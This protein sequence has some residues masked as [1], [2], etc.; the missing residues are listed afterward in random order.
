M[1]KKISLKNN[2]SLIKQ[3]ETLKKR[4]RHRLLGSIFILI[5]ALILLLN[6]TSRE[7]NIII[8]P[9][10]I[11]VNG[12]NINSEYK[13]NNSK[14]VDTKGDNIIKNINNHESSSLAVMTPDE[15]I[16][17][18]AEHFKAMVIATDNG[19][20]TATKVS[21]ADSQVKPDNH[22]HLDNYN[23]LND[24][25]P[26]FKAQ[27][28]VEKVQADISPEDI[29]N[30]N[31]SNSAISSNQYYVQLLASSNKSRLEKLQQQL[32]DKR[33]LKTIIQPSQSLHGTVYRLR[34]GPYS[35]NT[36]AD[37]QLKKINGE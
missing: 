25:I 28:V 29:L 5:L 26:K 16:V 31:T 10:V 24:G 20:M 9:Q 3:T 15:T 34:V 17:D 37:N 2:S 35:S 4:A 7:E 22:N 18:S 13:D 36:M 30:G 14:D 19:T 1:L 11:S 8:R 32:L 6:V 27:I 12:Y 21:K 23:H 33:G